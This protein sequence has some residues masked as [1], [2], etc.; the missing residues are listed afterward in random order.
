MHAFIH[1]MNMSL[2]PVMF[3]YSDSGGTSKK[4]EKKAYMNS[5]SCEASILVEKD[6]I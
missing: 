2:G 6:K 1:S 3:G 5:S 4:K